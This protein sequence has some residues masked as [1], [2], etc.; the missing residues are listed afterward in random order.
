M[1]PEEV[2]LVRPVNVATFHAT[3]WTGDDPDT[4]VAWMAEQFGWKVNGVFS[5][6]TAT[7]P[8]LLITGRNRTQYR[9][10]MGEWI[11]AL[12]TNGSLRIVTDRQFK[13]DYREASE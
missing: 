3:R 6:T 11:I 9:V 8:Y 1:R 5:R 12:G 10:K 7:S 4:D 13:R 2:L